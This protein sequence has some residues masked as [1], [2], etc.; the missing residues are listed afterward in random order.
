MAD[1][2]DAT[3]YDQHVT[4]GYRAPKGRRLDWPRVVAALGIVAVVAMALWMF[5]R[6]AQAPL[7]TGVVA[8]TDTWLEGQPFGA[9]EIVEVPAEMGE[10]F[11]APNDLEGMVAATRV[12]AGSLLAPQMLR[13]PAEQSTAETQ[14]RVTVDSHLWPDP[15]PA[16]GAVAVFAL[17]PGGCAVHLAELADG[18]RDA[19]TLELGTQQALEIVGLAASTTLLVWESPQAGWPGCDGNHL[20]G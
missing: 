10:R 11:V 1:A 20:G 15:G 4:T 18:Q 12:P 19:V 6:S 17:E 2:T 14:F 13:A 9:F 5:G 7:T 3:A 8:T 16:A